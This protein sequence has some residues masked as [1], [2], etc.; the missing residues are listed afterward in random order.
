M[1]LTQPAEGSRSLV[2]LRASQALLA[3]LRSNAHL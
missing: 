2:W 1:A 3:N